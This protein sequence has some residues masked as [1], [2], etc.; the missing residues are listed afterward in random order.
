MKKY[1]YN[2]IIAKNY[3]LKIFSFLDRK[4]LKNTALLIIF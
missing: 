1:L 3:E 2:I 4:L